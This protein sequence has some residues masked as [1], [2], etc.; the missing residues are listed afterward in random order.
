MALPKFGCPVKGKEVRGSSLGLF[1]GE[2]PQYLKYYSYK[3][4]KRHWL[5][6]ILTTDRFVDLTAV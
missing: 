2:K 5:S 4:E 3:D 6:M 1:L